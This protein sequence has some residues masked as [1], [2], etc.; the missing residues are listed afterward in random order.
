[1]QISIMLVDDIDIAIDLLFKHDRPRA[2]LN[3]LTSMRIAKKPFRVDQCV[4][5]LLDALSSN[6]SVYDMEKYH[7]VELI[8]L[9][10]SE[11]SVAQDDLFKIEWAYLPLL[12]RHGGAVPKLL[13]NTLTN[14]PEFFCEVI[15]LIYRSEKEGRSQK[16]STEAAK[17]NA[18]K[19]WKL[20]REWKTPPGTQEDGSFNADDFIEWLQ[21][22]KVI[23]TE[24]GHLDI[25]LYYVGQVLAYSPAD[26]DGL[27]IHKTI[28][29][30][31]NARDAD[32]MRR[33]YRTRTVQQTR[34]TR[35]ALYRPNRRT[36]EISSGRTVP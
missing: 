5:A 13:E 24:S 21:R 10:Q 14:D 6:E 34:Q 1:M 7:I 12:N 27:W 30:A 11:P 29:A 3:L 18:S 2:V 4:Q 19:A 26:P 22:V 25:S 31:M 9:L 20:L 23:C 28:A 16:K 33:G 15:R 36:P 8:K 32:E 35:H 17:A